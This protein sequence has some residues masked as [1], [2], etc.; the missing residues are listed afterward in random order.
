MATP[1]TDLFDDIAMWRAQA[2]ADL[3]LSGIELVAAISPGPAFPMMLYALA[4]HVPRSIDTSSES[5]IVDLGAGMGGASA[6][7]AAATGANVICVEP[8][9]GSRW[10]AQRLFPGL[11][12]RS[13]TATNSGLPSGCADVVVALGVTSLLDDLTGL[14]AEASR[15]LRPN[16]F[17]G[18]ADMFLTAGDVESDS[19]NTLRSLPATLA[20]AQTAGFQA[21]MI[22][23]GADAEPAAEWSAAAERLRSKV[24]DTHHSTPA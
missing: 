19:T 10:A 18:L 8:A 4:D 13:G 22:R 14:F 17:L 7:L 20:N 21:T 9:D 1:Q 15:L 23:C 2:A 11:D 6:W 16:G 3:G 12:V 24:I 5:T